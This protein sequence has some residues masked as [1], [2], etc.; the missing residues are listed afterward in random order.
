MYFTKFNLKLAAA[1]FALLASN[2]LFAAPETGLGAVYTSRLHGHTTACGQKYNKHKLT[3]AHA[4]LPC[5]SK[6]KITNTD[7][8]KSV[9]LIVNDRGPTQAGRLVDISL[10][11]SKALGLRRPAMFPAKLDVI[12]TGKH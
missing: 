6:V 3:T 11:A 7:N 2:S 1:A 10:R 12:R 9:V 5:G 4:S 8:G